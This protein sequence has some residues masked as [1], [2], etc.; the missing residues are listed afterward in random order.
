MWPDFSV[1]SFYK[2]IL[3]YQLNQ[4]EIKVN[5]ESTFLFNIQYN[6]RLKT[7]KKMIPS[8]SAAQLERQ[9]EANVNGKSERVENFLSDLYESRSR[10]T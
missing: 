3:Y 5:F 1:W 10:Y 2:G 8:I 7:L 6:N 9:N 4:I